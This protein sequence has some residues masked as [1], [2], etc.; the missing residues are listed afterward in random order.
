MKGLRKRVTDTLLKWGR[1][2][3]IWH[4]WAALKRGIGVLREVFRYSLV[5]PDRGQLFYVVSCERNA[6]EAVVRCLDSVHSQRAVHL[7]HLLVDDA[8]SD[9]TDDLVRD[10]LARHP[11]HRVEYRRNPTRKGGTPNTI[12]SF[13][14]APADSIVVELNG[15][16]WL[17]DTAVLSFISKVYRDSDV[18][19]TFNTM[20][21]SDGAV[22][23][24]AAAAPQIVR[25][26]R[27]W[28]SYGH[29][30][31]QHLHT[32][33]KELFN[34]VKEKSL[35]DPETGRYWES[36]DDIAIY[37]S[38]LELAGHH[39]KHIHRITYIYNCR[40]S[41]HVAFEREATRGR[42]KRIRN[43]PKY[44]TLDSL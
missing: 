34:H 41:S 37:M 29:W 42:E 20:E 13:R 28:R 24:G 23:R 16:D 3:N 15:D 12:E 18:W 1:P 11:D 35:I 43:L 31:T 2:I 8:S 38:M 32:F 25:K 26:N 30:I 39:A 17:P 21:R 33:R 5:S 27:E 19:M 44:E 4:K 14:N 36:A 6:G 10:W 7:R 22:F 9:R 40:P